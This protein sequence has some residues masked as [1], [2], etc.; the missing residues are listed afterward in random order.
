VARRQ[1]ALPRAVELH[2][3]ALELASTDGEQLD[4]HEQLGR[5]HDAAYHGEDAMAE[6]QA[7]LEL[8]RRDPDAKPRLARLARRMSSLVTS[9]GGSFRKRPDLAAV[10]ALIGEGLEATQDRRERAALLIASASMAATWDTAGKPDP[11]PIEVR[12]AAA[13]E[14]GALA[15]E[16]DDPG[17]LFVATISLRD[18]HVFSGDH[19]AAA[20]TVDVLLPLLERIRSGTR[21]AQLTAQ[22]TYEAAEALVRSRGDARAAEP[23]AL[24][25]REVSWALSRH[26]QMHATS[27]LMTIGFRLGDWDQVE[28][29]LAEHLVNLESEMHVRCGNVQGGPNHG[30]LV[31]ALRGDRERALALARRTLTFEHRPGP[32][33]GE[34]ADVLVAAGAVEEGLQQARLVLGQAS[35]WLQFEA[36]VAALHAL[37]ALGSWDEL[38]EVAEGLADLRAGSPSLDALADRALGEHLVAKGD[39]AAGLSLLRRA[40]ERFDEL[41][42][43]FEAARSREILAEHVDPAEARSLLEA[44]LA[45]YE[46]L[47]A[48]PSA[49][50]VRKRLAT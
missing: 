42:I 38:G 15:R 12:L 3:A 20:Q 48:A 27:I 13:R 50:R 21:T 14:A 7:A 46:R 33:E 17:L 36:S 44:A 40:V 34:A 39:A 1:F 5:D 24:Q 10:E 19:A 30:A 18:L 11:T 2:R 45:T 37:E 16:I 26:D 49:E 29:L 6:Y 35:R 8:A 41:P 4:A 22:S 23:L 31:L 43:V 25:S 9:R 28:S 47:G 32:V